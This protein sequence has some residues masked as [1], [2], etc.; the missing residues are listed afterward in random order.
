MFFITVSAL[1]NCL[2]GCIVLNPHAIWFD[3]CKYLSH[4]GLG[5]HSC[6]T[7]C[8]QYEINIGG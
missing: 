7:C 6:S 3:G 5:G 2:C 1:K 8:G 4:P